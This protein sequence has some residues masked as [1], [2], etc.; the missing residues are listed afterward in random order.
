MAQTFTVRHPV[1]PQ[2]IDAF[3]AA[4]VCAAIGDYNVP[5][6]QMEFYYKLVN[7][8]QVTI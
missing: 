8:L 3:K 4:E 5:R 1:V 2:D 6:N 7:L